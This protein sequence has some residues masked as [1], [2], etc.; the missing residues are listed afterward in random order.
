MELKTV[1]AVYELEYEDEPELVMVFESNKDARDFKDE[2]NKER[3]GRMVS[4][5]IKPTQFK[6]REIW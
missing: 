6:P 4:Y 2:K 1:Y 5:F 3:G